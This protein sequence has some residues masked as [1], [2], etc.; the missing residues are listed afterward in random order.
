[1]AGSGFTVARPTGFHWLNQRTY[2]AGLR[3]FVTLAPAL[4]DTTRELPACGQ[5]WS[6]TRRTKRQF[7]A[8]CRL[9]PDIAAD[10]LERRLASFGQ[11]APLEL[12]L[13]GRT[14]VLKDR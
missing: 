7:E 4:A 2:K 6:G 11:A 14:F 3:L 13:H 12:D 10:E 5:H 8:M 9:A 1:M